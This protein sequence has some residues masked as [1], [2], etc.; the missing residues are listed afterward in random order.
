MHRLIEKV[1]KVE[2]PMINIT[3]R[4]LHY[5]FSLSSK[6]INDKK[7]NNFKNLGYWIGKVTIN[8]GRIIPI[9]KL[10]LREILINSYIHN[11]GIRISM[12][13][14]VILKML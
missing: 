12:N 2:K 14:P 9:H 5:W 10:N 4:I 6:S 7:H 11:N 1:P 13:V 8:R 3:Y